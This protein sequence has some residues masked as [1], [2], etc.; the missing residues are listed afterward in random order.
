MQNDIPNQK[1]LNAFGVS[2]KP[3]LLP[4]GQGTCYRVKDV[5]FKPTNDAIEASWLAEI[6]NGLR[7]NKFRVPKPL[8]AKNGSWVFAGWTVSEF[9]EGEHRPGHYIE[10]I[11]LNRV[12]CTVL[13]NVSK[14][15]WFDKKTDVFSIADKIAWG[16]LS[17]PNFELT[18]E[19]LKRIFSF[20]RKNEL[21]NQLIHSDWSL[22]QILFHNT[23]PPAVIDMTPYF[24]PADYPIADMIIEAVVWNGADLSILDLGKN[25]KDFDQL[26]LRALVFR[27]CTYVGF[28]THPENDRDW[29]TEISHYLKILDIIFNK[30]K[31]LGF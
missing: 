3:I 18:K 1:I 19:P 26:L 24:R 28:Q 16:E 8:L 20:L 10:A 29:T 15:E 14:P 30:I 6:N 21:P 7:S 2:G 27:I 5:V 12:F 25:I 9:L 31:S 4:G 17:L 13:I 11:E 22:D 23:L